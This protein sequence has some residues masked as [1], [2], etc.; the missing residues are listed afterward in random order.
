VTQSRHVIASIGRR[1]GLSR[2]PSASAHPV[3]PR[4]RLVK[5]LEANRQLRTVIELA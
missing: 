1:A 3:R 2:E 5:E 4:V